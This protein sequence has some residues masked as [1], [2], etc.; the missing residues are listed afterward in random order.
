MD[1]ITFLCGD[2][3]SVDYIQIFI[4]IFFNVCPSDYIVVAGSGMLR[5]QNLVNHISWMVVATLFVPTVDPQLLCNQIFGGLF[6]LLQH[7]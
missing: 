4:Y 3:W 1:F 5:L 7:I 2:C 6:A